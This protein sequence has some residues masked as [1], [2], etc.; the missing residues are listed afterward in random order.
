MFVAADDTRPRHV[1]AAT[2]LDY[3]TMAGGDKFGNVFVNRLTADL[4]KE[5]ED[6]PTAGKNAEF[7]EN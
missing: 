3:D 6:D 5:M 2:P 4:S 7:G 1:T